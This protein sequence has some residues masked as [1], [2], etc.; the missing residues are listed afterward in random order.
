MVTSKTHALFFVLRRLFNS[1]FVLLA[2][3]LLIFFFLRAIP[4]DPVLTL[5]G[6]GE[7]TAEQYDRLKKELGD[8]N[9]FESYRM[10]G[11]HTIAS[12]SDSTRAIR[13]V[14]DLVNHA[15]K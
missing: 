13:S 1:V 14:A 11:Y 4:G 3:S 9:Q 15:G 2:L 8:E 10:L 5:L 12:M 7:T 6:E